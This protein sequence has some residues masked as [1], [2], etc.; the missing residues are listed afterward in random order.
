MS[1]QSNAPGSVTDCESIQAV[2]FAYLTRELGTAQSDL[3]REHLRRCPACQAE[4]AGIQQT[5][6]LLREASRSNS[7]VPGRLSDERR[8]RMLFAFM[9]PVL[10][11]IYA[12]H[13]LVSILVTLAALFLLLGVLD[14]VRDRHAEKLDMGIEVKVGQPG[15]AR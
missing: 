14:K 1:K 7:G 9:H 2:L 3:V 11:W 13:I 8:A 4:A 6:H 15:D 12:H 5:L 10:D